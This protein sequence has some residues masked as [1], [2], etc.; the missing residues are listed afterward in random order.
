M[1]DQLASVRQDTGA[2]WSLFGD[3]AFALNVHL[4]R[5]LRGAAARSEAGKRYNQR[6]AAVSISIEHSFAEV[7]NR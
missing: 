5:M 1:L 6:M 7:L 3:S 4:Q 2:V